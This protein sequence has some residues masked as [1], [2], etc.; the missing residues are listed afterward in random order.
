[1]V[2]VRIKQKLVKWITV[3][4]EMEREER[5]TFFI[6][7]NP[8]SS[9]SRTGP[10]KV[11]SETMGDRGRESRLRLSIR[12][13]RSELYVTGCRA[14]KC[15]NGG[16]AGVALSWQPLVNNPIAGTATGLKNIARKA[17]KEQTFD[18]K[19][20]PRAFC[21]RCRNHGRH[22]PEARTNWAQWLAD[23]SVLPL[24]LLNDS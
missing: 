20:P 24:T 12:A 3:E 2:N 18:F 7:A 13:T 22:S 23:W 8:F 11:S 14:N 17:R 4:K 9:S 19:L 1:M 10:G 16:E 21:R 6:F 5:D 15:K